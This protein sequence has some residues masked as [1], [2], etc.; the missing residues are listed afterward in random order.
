MVQSW[1]IIRRKIRWN[2]LGDNRGGNIAIRFIHLQ[3][4]VLAIRTFV[5]P[6]E[7]IVASKAQPLF[8][9]QLHFCCRQF[10]HRWQRLSCRRRKERRQCRADLVDVSEEEDELDGEVRIDEEGTIGF[11]RATELCNR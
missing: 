11:V 4:H 10:F 8:P 2:R 7:F 3:N 6:R 5:L 1:R 9:S